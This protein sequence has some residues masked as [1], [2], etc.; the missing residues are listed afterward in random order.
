LS[1]DRTVAA[2]GVARAVVAAGLPAEYADKLV[3]AA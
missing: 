2:E 1:I 3:T